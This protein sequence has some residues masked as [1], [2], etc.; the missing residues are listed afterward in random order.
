MVKKDGVLDDVYVW[1]ENVFVDIVVLIFDND[2]VCGEVVGIDVGLEEVFVVV[3][4]KCVIGYFLFV[5]EVGYLIGVRYN[6][7]VD[8][9]FGVVYGYYIKDWSWWLVMLYNC[10]GWCIRF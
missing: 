2:E 10:L 5:Y 8:L 7:E 6:I 1:W 3:Y 9:I 4:Y